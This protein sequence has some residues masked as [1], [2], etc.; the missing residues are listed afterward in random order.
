M[1]RPRDAITPSFWRALSL[2]PPIV[3]RLNARVPTAG[4][5]RRWPA[6]AEVAIAAG[7]AFSRV[8]AIS[9][10]LSWESVRIG[11]AERFCAAC[12]F[13]P[14]NAKDRKRMTDLLNICQ[15]KHP[16][17]PPHF[18]RSSPQW[19]TEIQPLISLLRDSIAPCADSARSA[20]RAVSSAA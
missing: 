15:K 16:N 19:E 9:Q 4:K 17:Q 12:R 14:T 10:S 3:V 8:L 2:F 1:G 11:E 7:M 5:H 20:F 13:D 6:H 18:L